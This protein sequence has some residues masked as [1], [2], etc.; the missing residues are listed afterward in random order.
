MTEN[1]CLNCNGTGVVLITPITLTISAPQYHVVCPNCN[2][3]GKKPVEQ[4]A[5]KPK[6]R[7]VKPLLRRLQTLKAREQKLI[8]QLTII[9]EDIEGLRERINLQLKENWEARNEE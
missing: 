6:F 3:T 8:V 1:K 5:Y 9:R 2:G 7:S 4:D